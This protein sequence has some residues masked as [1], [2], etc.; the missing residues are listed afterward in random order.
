MI[1][2]LS[3]VSEKESQL[4]YSAMGSVSILSKSMKSRAISQGGESLHQSR[5]IG[6]SDNH[7]H[8]SGTMMSIDPYSSQDVHAATQIDLSV[9]E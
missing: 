3:T 8:N 9:R 1:P 5:F 4:E 7:P 2:P 6:G